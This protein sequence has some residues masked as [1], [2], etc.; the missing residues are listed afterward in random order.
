[1][2]PDNVAVDLTQN[3]NISQN[4]VQ[5][6][7]SSSGSFSYGSNTNVQVPEWEKKVESS[8]YHNFGGES[9]AENTKANMQLSQ[10]EKDVKQLLQGCTFTKDQYDHILRMFK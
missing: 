5:S 7:F 3:L 9:I 6:T 4:V 10:A 1:M 2:A 8:T